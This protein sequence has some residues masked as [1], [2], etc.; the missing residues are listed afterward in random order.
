MAAF[1]LKRSLGRSSP[2]IAVFLATVMLCGC[3]EEGRNQRRCF[4]DDSTPDVRIAGCTWV[5][6]YSGE[7]AEYLAQAY[8]G[9]AR[10][11]L[12]K[13]DMASA[14]VD[15][16]EAIRLQPG[17]AEAWFDRGYIRMLLHQSD[18]AVGDFNEA[19]RLQPTNAVALRWRDA[20][21]AGK[22]IPSSPP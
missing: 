1:P 19:L 14:L 22:A 9:R 21:R 8:V 12:R 3:G 13:S 17:L 6:T 7:A 16:N 4:A 15:L 5:I 11:H 10:A 20:A 18:L 2:F